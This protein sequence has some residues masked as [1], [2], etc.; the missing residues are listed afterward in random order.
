MFY[1]TRAREVF[2]NE[3]LV[4]W[5]LNFPFVCE[6]RQGCS[7]SGTWEWMHLFVRISSIEVKNSR[8]FVFHEYIVTSQFC[9]CYITLDTISV[10]KTLLAHQEFQHD[11]VL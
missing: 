5:F 2:A 8:Q 1:S 11:I 10:I 7:T 3:Y 4:G 6:I 9:R